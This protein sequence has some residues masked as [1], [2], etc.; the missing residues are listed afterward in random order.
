[1]AV[2]LSEGPSYPE[3]SPHTNHF[4]LCS[5]LNDRR[6]A[7]P[8]FFKIGCLY[9]LFSCLSLARLHLLIFL[10]LMSG[11]VYPNPGPVFTCS[12]CPKNVTWRDR[13]V[14]CCTCFKRVRLKCSLLSFSKFKTI[15]NSHF[16]SCPSATFLLLWE[17]PT[18]QHSDFLLGL[19][20]LVHLYCSI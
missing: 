20:Q 14:Q 17:V 16:W 7:A 9:S 13:S 5:P 1:M 2:G 6:R 18:Y 10:L 8:S 15:G 3:N 19:F 4:L 11:H 12:V